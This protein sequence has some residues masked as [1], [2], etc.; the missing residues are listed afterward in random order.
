MDVSGDEY[1]PTEDEVADEANRE[2]LI[3]LNATRWDRFLSWVRDIELPWT[4]DTDEYR[5]GRALRYANHARAVSRNLY[6]LKPTMASWVP[7]IA[8]NIAPR[9]IVDF[10]DPTRRSADA[11]ESYGSCAKKVIK[12][13]TC[14]RQITSGFRRGVIEQA[15]RRL[16]VRSGLT[17]GEANL[18]F[19]QR[20]DA[21]LLGSGRTSSDN[22]R[23]EGPHH[24]IRVKVEAEALA[25]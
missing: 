9:Q 21:K 24:S 16:V 5:R 19:L 11:C 8:C 15:F 22:M 14:Q 7:H 13:L 4:S 10:G 18:P 17:H 3:V 23:A 1:E 12:L 6:D 25:A 2:P 20:E